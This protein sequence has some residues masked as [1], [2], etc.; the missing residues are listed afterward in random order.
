MLDSFRFWLKSPTGGAWFSGLTVF[1]VLAVA[2]CYTASPTVALGH[3]TGELMT[4][5]IVQAV[6]HSPGY[7]L[8]AEIGQCIEQLFSGYGD[9]AWR[10]NIYAALCVA[11]GGAFLA[12]GLSLPYGVVA[13]IISA[14][15]CGF[16]TFIWRQAVGA[17]VFSLQIFFLS[18]LVYLALLWERANDER[19]RY[20]LLW[21][22][23][24]MGCCLAH[25]HIIA[26]AGPPMILFGLMRKGRGRPWGFSLLNVPI[27]L[28][29]WM[30]PYYIQML[31]SRTKPPINWTDPSTPQ[32]L[33][34]H[35]LRKTYGTFSINAS[36]AEN[37][38][39]AGQAHAS[40]FYVSL[41][42]SQYPLPEPFLI[43]F[44]L[45]A[46]LMRSRLA[47]GVLFLGIAMMYG[48]VFA[49]IGNQPN[50]AFFMDLIERFYSNS[51]VGW[52]G[53][54]AIGI[55]SLQGRLVGYRRRI[56]EVLLI[57]L[58]ILS[59]NLNFDRASQRG[60]GQAYD[61]CRLQM[62]QMP[63]N[64][65]F[66]CLGDLNSGVADY[67]HLVEHRFP[68][69]TVVLPGLIVSDWYTA[70]LPPDLAKVV[71]ECQGD[72]ETKL[73]ALI[74]YCNKQNRPVTSNYTAEQLNC[75]YLDYGMYFLCLPK[76][77]VLKDPKA[78][79]QQLAKNFDQMIAWPK[80]GYM[81]ASWKTNFW[82]SFFITEWARCFENAA[83]LLQERDPARARLA[84]E[85]VIAFREVPETKVLLNHALLSFALKD[86][87]TAERDC[88]QVL[89]LEP[90][91]IYA[92]AL[93]VDVCR[94]AGD[95]KAADIWQRQLMELKR[96]QLGQLA[97]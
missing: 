56:F 24:V 43:L 4:C 5:S 65:V 53:L 40:V 70:T 48:P 59:Y 95:A 54:I 87:G 30:L 19:R 25:H 26:F 76:D 23:F 46:V 50:Q 55:H 29:A 35:F 63:P 67:I 13:G 91:N 69:M 44:G 1:A 27:L 17:E 64:S 89:G 41:L 93:L 47:H 38:E 36:A 52:A 39:R 80:R 2:Y 32:R 31:V 37:D 82:Q 33:L 84:L 88:M 97:R 60:Q 10:Q 72:H 71:D 22:S 20:I 81:K 75:V 86:Y 11:G 57:L 14:L 28:C 42:R 68:K 94:K 62:E 74:S 15:L 96:A 8:Y 66:L 9:P 3:D 85:Q 16:S 77:F 7:P 18:V 34:D 78:Y 6:P 73:A 92:T 90:T 61:Y 21:T 12:A 49:L 45:D 58:P 51:M 79:Y 83:S